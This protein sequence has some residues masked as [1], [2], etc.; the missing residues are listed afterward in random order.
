MLNEKL[1]ATFKAFAAFCERES[2]SY[3]MAYGSAI[4]TVRHKGMIPWDDDIDVFMPMPDFKRFV[5]MTAPEGYEIAHLKEEGINYPFTYGKFCDLSST[6]WEQ[7]KYPALL[8]VFVDVFPLYPVPYEKA[9][10]LRVEYTKRLVAY[11]RGMR[12]HSLSVWMSAG[13][14]D[15]LAAIQDLLYYRHI[16]RRSKRRLLEYDAFVQKLSGDAYIIYDNFSGDEKVLYRGE[17]FDG[18]ALYG[19]F[20]GIKVPLPCGNDALLRQ[21]Y[22]DYMTPPPVEK[23]ASWHHHYFMDLNRRLTLAEAKAAVRKEGR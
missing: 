4:G 7:R 8:G 6:V 5:G 9:H 10:E 1:I 3:Y 16:C 23:R 20:E 18:P 13:L 12:R 11:K 15:K 21:I 17:L 14:H 2:L 19:D 22:G